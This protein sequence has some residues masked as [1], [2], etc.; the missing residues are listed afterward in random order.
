LLPGVIASGSSAAFV[1]VTR[2]G[3]LTSI[4][5]FRGQRR[6]GCDKLGRWRAADRIQKP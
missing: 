1:A 3:R 6:R 4:D 2:V 5:Q